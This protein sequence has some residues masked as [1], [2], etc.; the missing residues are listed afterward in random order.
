MFTNKYSKGVVVIIYEGRQVVDL[1]EPFALERAKKLS[2][3]EHANV[4][5]YA[6]SP[7]N[8]WPRARAGPAPGYRDGPA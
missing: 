5:P 3:A 1:L 6:G 8:R 7:A 2:A 4:Q